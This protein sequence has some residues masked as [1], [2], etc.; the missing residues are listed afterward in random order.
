MKKNN[1]FNN[2][3]M[4]KDLKKYHKKILKWVK[5]KDNYNRLMKAK[6]DF[7]YSELIAKCVLYLGF[8][9][10][11]ENEPT[12]IYLALKK[13]REEAEESARLH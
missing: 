5:R 10:E 8:D 1:R 2:K 13:F 6:D 11:D 4:K 7:D 3:L 12:F 9:L